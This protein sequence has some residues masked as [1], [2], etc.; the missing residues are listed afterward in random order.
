MHQRESGGSPTLC[1]ECGQ[2]VPD[3]QVAVLVAWAGEEGERVP[4]WAFVGHARCADLVVAHLQREH[5]IPVE[6]DHDGYWFQRV[7]DLGREAS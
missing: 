6:L 7:I 4:D 5:G 1:D 2:A 3:D